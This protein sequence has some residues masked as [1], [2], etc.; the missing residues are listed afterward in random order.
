MTNILEFATHQHVAVLTLNDPSTRNSLGSDELFEAFEKAAS[1]IN[2]DMTVRVVVLTATGTVFCSGGNL[3]QMQAKE[4]MFGG[5]APE[6]ASQYER[7][8][9][10]IPRALFQ[11]DV[12]TIAAVNGPAIGAGCDLA[13]AC[14]IRI[15]STKA[16]FAESYGK[17]GLVPGFG[18]TWFLPRIVGYSR[19]AE[20]AFGG[21]PLDA[22][23]AL[24][25]GLVSRVLAPEA[26][27]QDAMNLAERIAANPP[28]V[29]RWTK[30]LLRESHSLSLD[31][32]LNLAAAYQAMAHG[33][34]DHAEGV[35]ALLEK[36]TPV[37]TGN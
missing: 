24:K 29:L 23:E 27:M 13:C 30:R 5:T 8:I 36:R 14:D 4:G 9:Q 20:M 35:N 37:F 28:Y 22:E 12:P 31:Q 11:I 34:T 6:I 33:T 16:L 7:G 10:R 25:A 26:L 2:A 15:A 21:A 3:R 32:T 19:A 1:K 17:V 18:G